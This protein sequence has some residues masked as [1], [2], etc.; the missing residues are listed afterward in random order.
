LGRILQWDRGEKE[1]ELVS[2]V[3]DVDSFMHTVEVYSH[4]VA[5]M[6]V[7]DADIDIRRRI[8]VLNKVPFEKKASVDVERVRYDSH[9]HL[10]HLESQLDLHITL[11]ASDSQKELWDLITK[12][13]LLLSARHVLSYYIEVVEFAANKFGVVG[14]D[15]VSQLKDMGDWLKEQT[16]AVTS[17]IKQLVNSDRPD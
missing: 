7:L 4:T 1:F 10:R 14:V 2:T 11:L 17:E 13:S 3:T 9:M 5:L 15:F 12:R 6:R 16:A 8:E